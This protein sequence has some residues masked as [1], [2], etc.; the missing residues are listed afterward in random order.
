MLLPEL[1]ISPCYHITDSFAQFSPPTS[2]GGGGE[3]DYTTHTY[4]II[5]HR[6]MDKKLSGR[7]WSLVD[8]DI[9]VGYI[10]TDFTRG[11]RI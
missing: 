5:T 11:K 7:N 4:I 9:T 8:G 3:E 6:G 2:M 10:I 1:E